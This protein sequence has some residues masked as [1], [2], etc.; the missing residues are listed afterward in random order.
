MASPAGTGRGA[1]RLL[2]IGRD[3][4]VP[5]TGLDLG[6]LPA[7]VLPSTVALYAE[8]GWQPPFVGYLAVEGSVAVG[9]C[10]FCSPPAAG[11]VEIAYFTFPGHER[12]GLAGFMAAALVAIA[13]EADPALT[14]YAQTLPGAIAS[15]TVL[16]RQG[17]ALA[18]SVRHPEDGLVWEWHRPPPA[19]AG[20][21]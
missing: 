21:A 20:R 3:G 16:A 15:A 6:V 1:R 18:R 19:G 10:A 13:R 5:A 14:L 9:A 11:R 4:T 7:E 12:R 17:F 8:R 2:P